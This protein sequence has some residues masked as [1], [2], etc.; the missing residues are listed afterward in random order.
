[1]I[2]SFLVSESSVSESSPKSNICLKEKL[3]ECLKE[4]NR[5]VKVKTDSWTKTETQRD[6]HVVASVLSHSARLNARGRRFRLPMGRA[7]RQ[8]PNADVST[9][10]YDVSRR[11]EAGKRDRF[12]GDFRRIKRRICCS[13][14]QPGKI[15]VARYAQFAIRRIGNRINLINTPGVPFYR[16]FIRSKCIPTENRSIK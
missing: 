7:S 13:D 6:S 14:E 10:N 9:G 3:F 5:Q 12:S 8:L 11:Y 4:Q 15:C 2:G 1:M 16:Y